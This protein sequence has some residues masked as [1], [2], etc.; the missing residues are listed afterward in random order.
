MIG[1][2]TGGA[3]NL[4]DEKVRLGGVG[5]RRREVSGGA[6]LGAAPFCIRPAMVLA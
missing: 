3:L 6:C 4:T 2:T 1:P 5:I